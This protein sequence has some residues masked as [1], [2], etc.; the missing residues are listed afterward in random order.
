HHYLGE[1]PPRHRLVWVERAIR[2]AAH[3]A[4]LGGSLHE[5]EEG[6]AYGYVGEPGRW[7]VDKLEAE[8]QHDDLGG[9]PP[10][11]RVG[12]AE[13]AVGIAADG[14]KAEHA[15]DEVVECGTGRHVR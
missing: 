9:L 6:R 14:P 2:V 10:G 11:G 15:P 5:S 8:G 13:S 12:G 4:L 1:L 7:R 3:D